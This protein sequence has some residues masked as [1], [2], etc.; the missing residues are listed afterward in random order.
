MGGSEMEA[1]TGWT[2]GKP[3]EIARGELCVRERDG[4]V[5]RGK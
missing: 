1:A 5:D 4:S 3:W 2:D